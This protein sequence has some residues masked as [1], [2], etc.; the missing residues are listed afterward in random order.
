M[1][2]TKKLYEKLEELNELQN[3]DTEIIQSLRETRRME[4]AETPIQKKY[5]ELNEKNESLKGQIKPIL[6]EAKQLQDEMVTLSEKKKVCED[7]LFSAGTDPK[8]LVFL[9][10]EREQYVNLHKLK[11]DKVI[12]LMVQVDGSEIKRREVEAKLK[13]I[14]E[15]YNRERKEIEARGQSLKNRVEELKEMRLRFKTFEDRSLLDMY[16]RIQVENDG[17]AIAT[18]I[19]DEAEP[20]DETKYC[21]GCQ[22]ELARSTISKLIMGDEIVYCQGCG[23]IIYSRELA[24]I[25]EMDEPEPAKVD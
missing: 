25:A 9:Q 13:E 6:A 24:N 1:K 8:D 3:I 14:E 15:E 11:E 2:V 18:I 23:R 5:V 4:K 22:V 19:S 17:L 16:R 12:K 20:K 7:K 10:K 21:S